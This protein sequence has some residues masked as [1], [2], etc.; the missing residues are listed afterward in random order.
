MPHESVPSDKLFRHIDADL[1][2][3]HRARHL[4]IW[5]AR[6]AA[7]PVPSSTTQDNPK[8]K[9]KKKA[10][11]TLNDA[12]SAIVALV[13]EKVVRQLMDLSIDIPLYDIGRGPFSKGEGRK[14]E[15]ADDPVNARN[16]E[17]KERLTK[18]EE[19]CVRVTTLGVY[20]FGNME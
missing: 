5:C 19:R 10:V 9:G 4:L 2:E 20:L 11:G 15:L 14:E 6:R 18:S 7:A 13:Q 1:P 16:R 12:D 3:P 8:G 17:L